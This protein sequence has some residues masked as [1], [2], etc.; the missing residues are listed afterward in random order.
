MKKIVIL[1]LLSFNMNLNAQDYFVTL[2]NALD[3]S[4]IVEGGVSFESCKAYLGKGNSLGISQNYLGF[5]TKLEY[6][7]SRQFKITSRFDMLNFKPRNGLVGVK[8][9]APFASKKVMKSGNSL[10]IVLVPEANFIFP[11]TKYDTES[12]YA[13]GNR[14]LGLGLGNTLW[15]PLY[16][17]N[18]DLHVFTGF[19]LFF[20]PV[21]KT[22]QLFS[23][24]G[25]ILGPMYLAAHFDWQK[26]FGQAD[27]FSGS[28]G[29]FR[30]LPASF[31]QAGLEVKY[32]HQYKWELG[33]EGDFLFRGQNVRKSLGALLKFTWILDFEMR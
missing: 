17:I 16:G 13:I 30:E 10:A 20:S 6:G 19:N 24:F 9:E 21:P 33:I 12:V 31:L 26:S 11:M 27:F 8:F 3:N 1:L 14:N 18:A 15:F 29:S 32:L 22:F 23:K 4:L 2:G 25:K 5:Q 7:L 28:F